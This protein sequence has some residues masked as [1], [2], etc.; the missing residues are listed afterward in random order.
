MPL[1]EGTRYRTIQ[2]AKGP[3]RLAFA[4]GTKGEVIEAVNLKTKDRHSLAEFAADRKK[5]TDKK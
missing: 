2:T 4:A 1:P 3:V 5:K